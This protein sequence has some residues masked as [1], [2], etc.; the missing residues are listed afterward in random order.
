[1]YIHAL[2]RDEKGAKMS[3]SKGNV[4]DPLDLMDEYGADALRFTLAA[5]AA[6]GRDVKIARG[7]VQ[8]YRNFATKLWNAVRFADM[9]ECR[10]DP[11]FD[12]TRTRTTL[13]RWI[14][15]ESTRTAE[16]VT[17]AVEAY[18]FNDA[19]A[20]LYRFT[21]NSFCDWYLELAKPV[22]TG[23]DTEEKRETRAA[24]AYVI[25]RILALLHPF[26]PFV[27]EEL[28]RVTAERSGIGRESLLIHARWPSGG[29]R[30]DSAADEINFV[31]DLIASV[32]SVRAESN[33]PA[34]MEAAIV[35]VS[36]SPDEEAWLARHDA[37]IRRL[38]R[39]ASVS[40]ADV[41]PPYSA[42]AVVGNV[43]VCLP[44]EG[45]VD[46]D[47]ERARLAKEVS[48]LEKDVARIDGRLSNERFLEK[49]DS[50]TVAE[51]REKRQDAEAR[52]TK[53]RT[54]LERLDP[55]A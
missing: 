22:L 44:L 1:V 34:A 23:P 26:M 29:L 3:K 43:V 41:A 33:V 38:A 12:P 2:V 35:V 54:A 14:L 49:A 50:E 32:R 37:A 25:D 30:D 27:T 31:V 51:Q 4:I 7:R 15:T 18:R 28:W 16:Q 24:T 11:S 46:L 40:V 52:L 48:R 47:A 20:A 45:L 21:W 17:E 8:G 55:A 10:M 13:V 53:L 6:Q 36:A 5:L 39:A 19:A 42:Q 9:N